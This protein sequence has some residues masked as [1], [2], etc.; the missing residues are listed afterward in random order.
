M[1][2][3]ITVYA[4]SNGDFEAEVWAKTVNAV[5]GPEKSFFLAYLAGFAMVR[6]Q[7]KVHFARWPI[8]PA[9]GHDIHVFDKL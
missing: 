8:A 7:E 4:K 9:L 5:F 2:P 6:G 3:C 1:R